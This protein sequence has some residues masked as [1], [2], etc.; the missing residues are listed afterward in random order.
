M[1]IKIPIS[2]ILVCTAAA[3]LLIISPL[4][5]NTNSDTNFNSFNIR[6]LFPEVK[7][8]IDFISKDI[9]FEDV[10]LKVITVEKGDNFWKIA[11]KN[12]VNINTLIAANPHWESLLASV[13]QKVVVPSERGVLHFIQ[14]LNELDQLSELFHTEKENIIIEK[15]PHLYKYYA[16]FWGEKKSIAVF[17]KGVKPEPNF[18]TPKL[19]KEYKRNQMF[20]SPLGGRL[21]SFFGKRKH[22]I[23]RNKS[24]HNGIDIAARTGTAV[25][26]SRAGR[27]I[28]TGWMGGYGKAVVIVHSNGYKTLYGHL[29]RITTRPGRKVKAGSLIGRVGSTG[30]STGPHLHFTLWQNGKLLNPLKVLW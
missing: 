25:G 22:P 24:F 9:Q 6:S 14:D 11:K 26:A 13:D 20:R 27:V 16:S 21:S 18:M 15:L 10:S 4:I 3:L 28:A 17:I 8:Y 19:A 12:S 30:W 7:T 2:L 29:S 5:S 23:F 1:K